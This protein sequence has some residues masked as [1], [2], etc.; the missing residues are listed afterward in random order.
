MLLHEEK[1]QSN[2]KKIKEKGRKKQIQ[3]MQ[4]DMSLT[5][6]DFLYSK[7]YLLF[8]FLQKTK[9]NKTKNKQT[10]KQTNKKKNK[11]KK[12]KK[13]NTHTHTPPHTKKKNTLYSLQRHRK[14]C[15]STEYLLNKA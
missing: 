9:Q 15:I 13:K 6:Y 7:Q 5:F 14:V 10:N 3:L 1:K 12:T 11:K 4:N 8:A 2:K